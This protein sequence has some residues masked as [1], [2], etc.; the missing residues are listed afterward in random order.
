MA[1]RTSGDPLRILFVSRAYPP[2]LGGIENH[3]FGIATALG[4]ITPTTVIA[5]TRGK[6]FLPLFLP[7]ALVRIL[8]ALPSHDVVL[9]GDGVLA[10]LARVARWFFPRVTWACVIHGLDV[11][12]AT[13]KSTMGAIYRAVTIPALQTMDVLIAVGRQTIDE[14]V[15]HG[16]DR[17]RCVFIPNGVDPQEYY[18]PHLTRSDLDRLLGIVT[19]D[20]K[21]L[22]RMGRFVAHKGLVWFI[23]NVMPLLP[24]D[25]ILVAM[26]GAPARATVGDGT[27]LAQAQQAARA[28]GL[29]DRVIFLPNRPDSEKI[30][31]FNTVDLVVSP[32]ISVPGSME[33]FGINAIETAVCERVVVAANFQGLPDA[34]H[35]GKNGFLLPREDAEAWR[36]KIMELLDDAFDRAAFGQAAR[37]Y[38]VAH[39]SWDGIARRY[40]DALAAAHNTSQ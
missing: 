39:F 28:R 1:H 23:D 14:A 38:T 20:K 8:R 13:K 5:N 2:V 25:V 11:T 21:V 7:Y 33:G 12:Y 31:L 24:S 26:G 29:T 18:R 22:L 3:N 37:T 27:I 40:Y 4:A 34:V 16:V 10:P 6:K 35:D 9:F 15:A 19:A 17:A 32:N 30:I 36:A